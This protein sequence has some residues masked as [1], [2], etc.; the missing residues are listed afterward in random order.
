MIQAQVTTPEQK[1][2]MSRVRPAKSSA[3]VANTPEKTCEPSL[4]VLG[5][6]KG[7]GGLCWLP[8]NAHPPSI[9]P[10]PPT[11]WLGPRIKPRGFM[12]TTSAIGRK[13]RMRRIAAGRERWRVTQKSIRVN[14]CWARCPSA[15][16]TRKQRKT[17]ATPRVQPSYSFGRVEFDRSDKSRAGPG[18][19]GQLER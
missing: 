14:D 7:G 3:R 8:S 11:P 16:E 5:H 1:P 2:V 4:S 12:R 9:S 15:R 13:A 18:W 10:I 17:G 6:A 19:T